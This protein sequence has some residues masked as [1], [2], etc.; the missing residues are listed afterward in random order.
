MPVTVTYTV[1]FAIASDLKSGQVTIT[2]TTDYAGQLITASNVEFAWGF[3]NNAGT[4]RNVVLGQPDNILHSPGLSATVPL[5]TDING[6]VITGDYLFSWRI[7]S[8][9]GPIDESGGPD[10]HNLCSDFPAFV[11]TPDVNCLAAWVT[12]TD[13]TPWVAEGWTVNTRTLTLQYPQS[14]VQ[15]AD[16][17]SS[18]AVVSTA[19]EAIFRGQWKVFGEWNVTKDNL[20]VDIEGYETFDVFCN[21]DSCKRWCQIECAWQAWVDVRNDRNLEGK[22]RVK[23]ETMV[24]LSMMLDKAEACGDRTLIAR[25]SADYA[26]EAKNCGCGC[27][28]QDSDLISPIYGSSGNAPLVVAGQGIVVNYGAGTVTISLTQNEWDIIQGTYNTAI[29]SP[30]GTIT[31]GAPVITGGT[32]PLHTFPIEVA[33]VMPDYMEFRW[34]ISNTTGPVLALDTPT[35]VGTTFQIPGTIT[36]SGNLYIFT[37]LMAGAAVAFNVVPSLDAFVLRAPYSLSH[38]DHP[39][40]QPEIVNQTTTQFTLAIKADDPV[41]M[42]DH[43]A[44]HLVEWFDRHLS[45]FTILFKLTKRA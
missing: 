2:D 39:L 16:I 3:S 43:G 36:P 44:A 14:T 30:L 4:Y 1:E 5:P 13:E 38:R 6:D 17:T 29:S 27:D 18:T 33:K 23:W 25:L 42:T 34:I 22:A 45:S 21:T 40:I 19:G 11:F 37:N 31:V 24:K 15:H 28:Q 35:I 32:P 41:F 9:I 8:A 26:A 20:T 10:T 7:Y 12:V